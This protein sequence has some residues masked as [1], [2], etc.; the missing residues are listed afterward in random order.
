KEH[1]FIREVLEGLS[2]D[3]FTFPA[4]KSGDGI[5]GKNTISAGTIYQVE[6]TDS[7]LL[8]HLNFSISAGTMTKSTAAKAGTLTL[9]VSKLQLTARAPKTQFTIVED[10]PSILTAAASIHC[11][12]GNDWDWN[13]AKAKELADKLG[14]NVH[15]LKLSTAN[16]KKGQVYMAAAVSG[17]K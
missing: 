11:G 13:D 7:G 5:M 14:V 2:Y 3:V 10:G 6:G 4:Q 1:Q 8:Y 9:N 16:S 15:A 17:L 12:P